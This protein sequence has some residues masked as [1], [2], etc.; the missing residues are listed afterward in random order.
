MFFFY[1]CLS[2]LSQ[3]LKNSTS[4]AFAFNS[5]KYLFR[6][7]KFFQRNFAKIEFCAINAKNNQNYVLQRKKNR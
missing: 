6:E 5:K 7:I 1:F 4:A 3:K 2:S